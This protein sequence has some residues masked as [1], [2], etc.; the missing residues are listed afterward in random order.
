VNDEIKEAAIQQINITYVPDEDRLLLKIAISD[1]TELAVW[2]TRRVVKMLS[3]LLNNKQL[4][5]AVAPE[6]KL[7]EVLQQTSTI[8]NPHSPH[9]Q[10]LLQ[11]FAKEAAAQQL[12][13]SEQY[14]ARKTINNKSL[15]LA[16]SCQVSVMD[17][18]HAF[19]ELLC[20]REQS[21]KVGLNSTLLLALVN[22]LKLA[23]QQ[24]QWHITDL[25]NPL[26][27]SNSNTALLH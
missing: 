14:Q 19:L 7:P 20:T 1:E 17:N 3:E 11:D 24:A 2:L 23:V 12:N 18:E 10:N 22:I 8:H 25:E 5:D 16:S 21:V 9:T 4:I 6:L 13:F 27:L 15:L 26:L